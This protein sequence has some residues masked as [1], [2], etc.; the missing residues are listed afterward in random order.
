M[1]TAIAHLHFHRQF[2]RI[3]VN[4]HRTLTTILSKVHLILAVFT[5]QEILCHEAQYTITCVQVL[6]NF[7][8]PMAAYLQAL[9]IPNTQA[10]VL[11]GLDNRIDSVGILMGIADKNIGFITRICRG[12][13]HKHRSSLFLS[14]FYNFFS[15]KA[16]L[17]KEKG[18][19]KTDLFLI[20]FSFPK[21]KN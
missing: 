9:I 15:Q 13:I 6:G 2:D 3:Q 17:L 8:R 21:W 7:F 14:L 12:T 4:D 10:A 18:L 19:S 5:F 16:T 1:E 20:S 11:Q